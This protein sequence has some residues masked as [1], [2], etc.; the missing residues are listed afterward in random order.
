[1]A[2]GLGGC[3]ALQRSG[4]WLDQAEEIDDRK[5]FSLIGYVYDPA[6]QRC[7]HIIEYLTSRYPR[8]YQKPY[9]RPMFQFD[10]EEYLQKAQRQF[11]N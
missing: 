2:G 6:Y 7:L 8:E 9:V 3:E 10:W 4:V 11:G 5:L 1:M